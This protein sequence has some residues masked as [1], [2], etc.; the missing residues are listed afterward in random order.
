MFLHF[1]ALVLRFYISL[2]FCIDLLSAIVINLKYY[3][4]GLYNYHGFSDVDEDQISSQATYYFTNIE[5]KSKHCRLQ[6]LHWCPV[7]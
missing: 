6:G 2:F 4:L 1:V 5:V 3:A 7:H